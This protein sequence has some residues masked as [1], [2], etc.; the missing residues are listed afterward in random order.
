MYLDT[1]YMYITCKVVLCIFMCVYMCMEVVCVCRDTNLCIMFVYMYMH[2]VVLLCWRVEC[3]RLMMCL[4]QDW[5]D[6]L[7]GGEKQRMAV[8]LY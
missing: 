2:L 3:Y 4:L 5:M 1:C 6:L 8:S 7:S